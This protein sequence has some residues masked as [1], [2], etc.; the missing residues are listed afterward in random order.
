MKLRFNVGNKRQP[1]PFVFE[2]NGRF[3]LYVTADDG[4][5]AYSASGLFEEWQYEGVICSVDGWKKYWAPC[6]IKHEGRYYLYFS[7]Q[8]EGCFEW[9]HVAVGDSPLGPY[10][11]KKCLFDRFTIDAHVVE[12]A[13]GLF[14]FYAEDNRDGERIGTRVFVDCLIDPFTPAGIRREIILPTFEEEIFQKNRYGD[15]KDWYCIEG[16]FWF[17]EG[18]WQYV[19]YSAGCYENDSYHVGYAAAKSD[20]EDLTLVEFEKFTENGNFAPV[21]IKNEIEEGTGHHSLI[22]HKDQYYIIYHGRDAEPILHEEYVEGRTARI[23]GLRVGD[24]KITVERKCFPDA[25]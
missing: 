5:E 16:P 13:A 14:L 23:A 25:K 1:D 2:D 20:E 10:E 17:R 18:D 9:L 21:L 19:M 22:K 12:T 7:C 24:G 3:Y 11:E 6:I 8:K 15:G 4:V